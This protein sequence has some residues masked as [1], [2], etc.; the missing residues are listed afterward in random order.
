[1]KILVV[2]SDPRAAA[3]IE[4][5]CRL[6]LAD[7]LERFTT[8]DSVAAAT[9]QLSA[10]AFDVVLLDPQLP[11]GDGL[12]LLAARTAH[13]FQTIIVS[14]RTDLAL[15]AFDLDVLDFVPKPAG[16]DRLEKALR[17]VAVR[18][19][20]SPPDE[21]FL[22]VRR[23]GRIDLV[24]VADLLYVEGADKYSELVLA[25]GQRNFHDKAL[26]SLEA[27]LPQSFVRI[28]KSYLVRFTMVSRL[29]VLKGSRYYAELKNGLRLPVGRSRYEKVKSRLLWPQH[30][31]G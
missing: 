26:G 14:S 30:H 11:Q 24:A 17:R 16:R 9:A 7:R 5:S 19:T 31:R 18:P 12:D 8:A 4:Q 29:L 10:N 27:T 1:M 25:N 21:L 2:D 6:I 23:M 20:G 22:A 13:S 3:Q 15:R 28:H